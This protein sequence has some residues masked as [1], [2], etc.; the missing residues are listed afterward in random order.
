MAAKTLN[1]ERDL[2]KTPYFARLLRQAQISILEIFNIFLRL[3]FSPSLYSNKI[4]HFSKVS[5]NDMVYKITQKFDFSGTVT[6]SDL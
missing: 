3:K 6:T 5:F 2:C 1:T 4:E